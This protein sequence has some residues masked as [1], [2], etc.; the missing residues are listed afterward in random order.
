MD[1]FSRYLDYT[2]DTESPRIYH[3]WCAIASVGALLGRSLYL[4]HGHFRV[5]PNLY[6]MLIGNP[7]TRK[8]T[9]IKLS[10]RLLLESG[11]TTFAADKSSKEKF[12]IDLATDNADELGDIVATARGVKYD[13]VTSSN[14]WGTGDSASP[15]EVYIAADEFNEFSGTGNTEFFTTLGNLWDWDSKEDF[16]MRFKSGSIS[17]FQPTVSLLGGN[18]QENFA[19]AFPPEIIGQGFLSRLILIHGVRTD[20]KIPF[21]KTPPEEETKQLV[22][23]LSAVKGYLAGTPTEVELE[24]D[25]KIVLEAIY[26]ASP[27]VDDIRFAGYNNRRFIQLLK[28][29]VLFT[30]AELS[31]VCDVKTVIQANTVLSAAERF[32]PQ[33]LGEF[34]KSRN[35]DVANKIVRILE[36]A[37]SPVDLH[38]IW[39]QVHKDLDKISALGDLV[40]GLEQAGRVQ[41]I[42]GKGWLPKKDVKPEQKY[43]D[44]SILTTEE[45][46]DG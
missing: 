6:C 12:L 5:Y 26:L 2:E 17:I 42:K 14:L 35:S 32:M 10:R 36:E 18:T 44:W 41:H 11:Y 38:V 23:Y 39:K 28:L 3:R 29:C 43:V 19:R 33:A 4:Q 21:P 30:G 40:Q 24:E 22:D 37:S 1:F 8:S 34:G 16:L 25:A 27:E 31:T 9:A 46:E 7:A 20:R 45:R 13:N 15:K